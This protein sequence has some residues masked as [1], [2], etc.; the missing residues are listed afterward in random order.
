M[1]E[2][3]WEKYT[4]GNGIEWGTQLIDYDDVDNAGARGNLSVA[5]GKANLAYGE[6]SFAAGCRTKALGAASSSDGI[7]TIAGGKASHAGGYYTKTT[8]DAEFAVGRFNESTSDQTIF[9]VGNGEDEETRS[10]ALEVTL[11]DKT[12]VKKLQVLNP[13][14]TTAVTGLGLDEDNNVV[15]IEGSTSGVND[16]K[17]TITAA[18]TTI[19]EFTANQE[20]DTTLD[21]STDG[22]IE[23]TKT[24][25]GLNI[26]LVNPGL[27]ETSPLSIKVNGLELFQYKPAATQDFSLNLVA[28]SGIELTPADNNQITIRATNQATVNDGVLRVYAGNVLA[29]EFSA[30][31]SQD[32]TIQFQGSGGTSITSQG[33]VITINS[34][35]SIVPNNGQLQIKVNN[36]NVQ[37]F[38]ADQEDDVS[39]QIVGNIVSTPETGVIEINQTEVNDSRI[40]FTQGNRTLG[41]FTLNQDT[42]TTIDIPEPSDADIYF[43][44]G[45][46]ELGSFSLNQGI[47]QSID[48]AD[49][50]PSPPESTSPFE[51]V[52][53]NVR[54]INSDEPVQGDNNISF[55]TYK[56]QDTTSV[57][58]VTVL[59]DTEI[60]YEN[61]Y[62]GDSLSYTYNGDTFISKIVDKDDTS[63]TLEAPLITD[64]DI[65]NAIAAEY[66]TINLTVNKQNYLDG[67]QSVLFGENNKLYTGETSLIGGQDNVV[68][69]SFRSIISGISNAVGHSGSESDTYIENSILTGENNSICGSVNSIISGYNNKSKSTADNNIIAGESNAVQNTSNSLIIGSGNKTDAGVEETIITGTRNIIHGGENNII[70]GDNNVTSD[71]NDSIIAGGYN[72][73]IGNPSAEGLLLVGDHLTASK[74]YESALGQYNQSS[75]NTAF[76]IGTGTEPTR[77]KNAFEVTLDDTTI[78]RKGKI[79]EPPQTSAVAC[80]GLDSQHNIVSI[81]KLFAYQSETI[82]NSTSVEPMDYVFDFKDKDV[83][84][85]DFTL[86]NP[87]IDGY[88]VTLISKLNIENGPEPGCS[89]EYNLYIRSKNAV[90]TSGHSDIKLKGFLYDLQDELYNDGI[91]PGDFIRVA[92]RVFNFG[93]PALYSGHDQYEIVYEY[94][95]C[96]PAVSKVSGPPFNNDVV[97]IQY[98]EL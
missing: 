11:D 4:D 61:A 70:A 9:S 12:I 20:G 1:A 84:Y 34:Q 16:G 83:L 59:L 55:S 56:G 77:R 41:A 94:V 38:G 27:A 86:T 91:I 19:S 71:I 17:F 23:V 73:A 53:G 43:M 42:D 5:I 87:G 93:N 58:P 92:F 69:E 68:H 80:L 25:S 54:R 79:L 60:N 14:D 6:M 82:N 62:I 8:N 39:L 96:N 98:Y 64:A 13:G 37:N 49:W 52:D 78:I 26:S 66:S 65:Y 3:Y 24:Q 36:T 31:S 67:E 29:K 89:K 76:S 2:Q 33:N 51:E 21:I 97:T 45:D 88:D 81:L 90:Q 35:E 74:N 95:E 40:Q 57:L 18:G 85:V 48:L 30:N 50:I 63:V 32:K 10:N 47:S 72:S 15:L 46:I 7:H 22:N 44:N 75:N 28:G